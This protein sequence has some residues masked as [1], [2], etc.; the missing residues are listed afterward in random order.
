[1]F[2]CLNAKGGNYI[3]EVEL[4]AL[5]KELIDLSMHNDII[6]VFTEGEDLASHGLP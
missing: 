2:A 5:N 4:L 6:H 3:V 1:M